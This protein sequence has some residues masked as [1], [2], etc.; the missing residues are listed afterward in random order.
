M[1]SFSFTVKIIICLVAYYI[2]D[3]YFYIFLVLYSEASVIPPNS[4]D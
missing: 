4:L 1:V 2:G 3:C